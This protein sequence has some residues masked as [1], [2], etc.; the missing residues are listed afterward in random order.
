MTTVESRFIEDYEDDQE[1]SPPRSPRSPRED[2]EVLCEL[3]V[4][5]GEPLSI[6]E[7]Q[8]SQE[9]G[10]L[11]F[12]L[13]LQRT[14]SHRDT[15]FLLNSEFSIYARAQMAAASRSMSASSL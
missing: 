14:P 2:Q 6:Y 1:H 11:D 15:G 7:D 3:R 8:A 13:S 9:N 4:L 12:V 10:F 5:G